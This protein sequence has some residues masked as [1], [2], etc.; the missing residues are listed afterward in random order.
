M[1]KSHNI[2]DSHQAASSFVNAVNY[3]SSDHRNFPLP[4]LAFVGLSVSRISKKLLTNFDNIFE[5]ETSNRRIDFGGDPN[6]VADPGFL[7]EFYRC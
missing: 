5:S 7:K 6:H 2:F 1:R 4:S 3:L